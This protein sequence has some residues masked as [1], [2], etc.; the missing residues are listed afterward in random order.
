MSQIP[1]LYQLNMQNPSPIPYFFPQNHQFQMSAVNVPEEGQKSKLKNKNDGFK[2][3]FKNKQDNKPKGKENSK[4][5]GT[6]NSEK[7]QGKVEDKNENAE[8]GLEE[9]KGDMGT[10]SENDHKNLIY[11]RKDEASE[12]DALYSRV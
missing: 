10:S 3:D 9:Y 11:I 4:V 2:E 8:V 12:H 5:R 7:E 1:F 6:K